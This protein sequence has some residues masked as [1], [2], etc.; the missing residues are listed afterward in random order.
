MTEEALNTLE[1]K[2]S[3][4]NDIQKEKI[5]EMMLHSRSRYEDLGEKP[6]RYFFLI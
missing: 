3:I 4:S 2:K 1:T 5:E 6:R